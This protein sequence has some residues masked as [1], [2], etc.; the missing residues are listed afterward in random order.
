MKTYGQFC[1]IAKALEVVGERWSPLILRE[2]M[3]GSHR[4]S[5]IHRGIPRIS[6][7]LLSKRLGELEQAGVIA[8]DAASGGYTLTAAGMDLQPVIEQLGVWGQRWVRGQLNDEDFDPDV[9]MWDMRRRIDLSM[10]P[11]TQ[12]CLHFRIQDHSARPR[13]YWII[14]DQNGVELCISD[15]G[16]DPD[17]FITTDPKTLTYIWNGDLALLT[18]IDD[19]RVELHGSRALTKIFCRCLLLSRFAEVPAAQTAQASAQS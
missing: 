15:P 5:E 9:V 8:R 17:L 7:S 4:F 14:G 11:S 19:G 13:Q 3:C 1:S 2:L 12:I 16:Q 6:P 18:A 10:L